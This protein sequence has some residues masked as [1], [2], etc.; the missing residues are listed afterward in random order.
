VGLERKAVAD[1]LKALRLAGLT[2]GGKG[3]KGEAL[4]HRIIDGDSNHPY[5]NKPVSSSIPL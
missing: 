3:T 5:I 4:P 1:R 2:Q